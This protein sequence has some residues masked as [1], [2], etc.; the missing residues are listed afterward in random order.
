MANEI[1][2]G[3]CESSLAPCQLFR[4][5]ADERSVYAAIIRLNMQA[6]ARATVVEVARDFQVRL[7]K[8]EPIIAAAFV[9]QTA[10]EG[11]L[12]CTLLDSDDP[13]AD[14]QLARMQFGA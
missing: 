11:L 9:E 8:F 10:P 2:P 14:A 7:S 12:L 6:Q 5:T 3:P 1:T 4:L 13:K